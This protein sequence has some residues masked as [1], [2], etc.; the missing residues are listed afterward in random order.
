MRGEGICVSFV[1]STHGDF[2]PSGLL[3]NTPKN[4][5]KRPLSVN[6]N[7]KGKEI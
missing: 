7:L 5:F 4:V 6:H 1:Y 3:L 2:P